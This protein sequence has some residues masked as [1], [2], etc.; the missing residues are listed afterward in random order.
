MENFEHPYREKHLLD[1]PSYQCENVKNNSK[2]SHL[3]FG[4]GKKV[5]DKMSF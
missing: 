2:E 3:L 5:I 1:I 4:T